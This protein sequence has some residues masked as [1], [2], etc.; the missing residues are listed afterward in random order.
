MQHTEKPNGCAHYLIGKTMF[1]WLHSSAPNDT[2]LSRLDTNHLIF[3]FHCVEHEKTYYAIDQLKKCTNIFNGYKIFTI[4][5][6]TEPYFESKSF[7]ALVN[8]VK[9]WN[10][11]H[12]IPV[13]NS[14]SRRESEHFFNKAAPVLKAL[15]SSKDNSYQTNYVFYGHTKGITHPENSYSITA[16]VNTLWKYNIHYYHDFIK[17]QLPKYKFVGCLKTENFTMHGLASHCHYQ[18]TFFWFN[19]DILKDNTAWYKNYNHILSLELWPGIITKSD[20]C[21]SVFDLP[22]G[23]MYRFDY[24]YNQHFYGRIDKP[25]TV[26]YNK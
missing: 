6:T 7:K 25:H 8:V 14:L 23:D 16:W 19:A 18:G 20:E 9:E 21:Y 26:T 15:L 10:D 3:H 17:P 12:L 1:N 22:E 2:Q 4:S 11:I 24:W 13:D 5:S